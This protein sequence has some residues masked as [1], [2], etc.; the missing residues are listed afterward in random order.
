M[1]EIRRTNV[2][3]DPIMSKET[4]KKKMQMRK[5]RRKKKIRPGRKVKKTQSGQLKERTQV[6][7]RKD[8]NYMN[9]AVCKIECVL[10]LNAHTR[11]LVGKFPTFVHGMDSGHRV[12]LVNNRLLL[13]VVLQACL[14]QGFHRVQLGP[15]Y[16]HTTC[17]LVG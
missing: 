12:F 7:A 17:S 15:Y 13:W 5:Q 8:K 9:L 14:P 11:P 6:I 2:Q 16:S 10:F 1:R 4:Q 3:K